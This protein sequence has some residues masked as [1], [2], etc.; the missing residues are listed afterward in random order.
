M[1]RARPREVHVVHS[2]P[3][4][5][6]LRSSR[7]R[8]D[9]AHGTRVADILAGMDGIEEVQVRPLTGSLLCTYDP[10]CISEQLIVA[11]VDAVPSPPPEKSVRNHIHGSTVGRAVVEAFQEIDEE[12]REA[13]EN[14]IDLGTLAA[15]GFL[16]G[17][18]A[19][20]VTTRT[21]PAPPWFNLAWWAFRTLTVF[22]TD[23]SGDRR[24]GDT[25]GE[26]EGG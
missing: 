13:T 26:E 1:A 9:P 20:V 22:E 12:V 5:V 4:R 15:L 14:R 6:R 7:F 2:L 24:A 17:G 18:A 11:A 19:E 10:G 21:M 25:D 8:G 16:A 23:P 3:G